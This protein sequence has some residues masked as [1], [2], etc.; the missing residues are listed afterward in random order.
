MDLSEGISQHAWYPCTISYPYQDPQML[1]TTFWLW[2]RKSFENLSNSSRGPQEALTLVTL[3]Q[4]VC[5]PK[6]GVNCKAREPN[7]SQWGAS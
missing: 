2:V 3:S 7:T 1:P 6:E 5:L 4:M